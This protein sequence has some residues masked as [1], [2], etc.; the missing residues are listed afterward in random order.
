MLEPKRSFFSSYSPYISFELFLLK[1]FLKFLL[2]FL[3][4]HPDRDISQN[5]KSLLCWFRLYFT[6]LDVPAKRDFYQ[7]DVVSWGSK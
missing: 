3:L 7:E 1:G 2:L 6:E 5:K 4:F